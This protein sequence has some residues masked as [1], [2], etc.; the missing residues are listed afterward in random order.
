MAYLKRATALI[1]E[2]TVGTITTGTLGENVATSIAG[3]ITAS[4]MW[5][6]PSGYVSGTAHVQTSLVVQ[7]YAGSG[8]IGS[9]MGHSSGVFTFPSTGI[10]QIWLK[11]EMHDASAATQNYSTIETSIDNGSNY[12]VGD[13]SKQG[14]HGSN[15]GA[16]YMNSI[17]MFIFDV[18]SISGTDTRKCRFQH[19]PASDMTIAGGAFGRTCAIF[20]RLGDT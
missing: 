3:G 12:V 11:V 5:V 1:T 13:Y 10:W 4:Q 18:T 6:N 19:F 8:V 20:T 15:M 2:Q 14:L 16:M 7:N 9:S 17:G